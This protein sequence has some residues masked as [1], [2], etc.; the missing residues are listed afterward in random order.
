MAASQMAPIIIISG[1][2]ELGRIDPHQLMRV[3]VVED[4]EPVRE[5]TVK[6]LKEAGFTVD[7]YS[8]PKEAASKL[9]ADG[10]QLV[11]MDIRF[12]EPNIPGD[13]FIKK[14]RDLFE[15]AKVVAFTGH[16]GDIIHR[17]VFHEVFLK[18]QARNTLYDFAA[19]TYRARQKA[20]ASHFE[21]EMD[22]TS[23]SGRGK[24]LEGT[25]IHSK[26]E[27]IKV[28]NETRNKDKKLVWYKGKELS[29]NDLI[30]EVQ[31]DK[32]PVGQ[33]HIRMMADRLLRRKKED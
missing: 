1:E 18:G 24:E 13:E 27:L 10:Y 3:L 23:A 19:E 8:T 22:P 2:H 12:E 25:L 21:N 6:K 33:S 14:N 20:V 26:D 30:K 7:A 16:Q 28:L 11:I 9:C 29:A 4:E 31:D 32:S 5:R 15:D 17:E